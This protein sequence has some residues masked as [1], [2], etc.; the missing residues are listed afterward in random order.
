MM[1]LQIF[2][3]LH[4]SFNKGLKLG[5]YNVNK[6]EIPFRSVTASIKCDFLQF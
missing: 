4:E 1:N 2:I 6:T 5:D 3:I